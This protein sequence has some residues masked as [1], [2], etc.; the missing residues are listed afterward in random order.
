[1]TTIR[2]TLKRL[3]PRAARDAIVAAR[4][5]LSA[6]PL[7]Q[8]VLHDY[9]IIEDPAP[10]G[11]LTLVMP[12]LASKTIFGG[13]STGV[14]ILFACAQALKM[15]VRV[16]ID[17]FGDPTDFSYVKGVAQ[18]VAFAHGDIEFVARSA[19]TQP[20][21]VRA[22]DIFI[23]FNWWVALNLR[24]MLAQQMILRSA[25]KPRPLLYIVQDYEPGFYPWSSTHMVARAAFDS[26]GRTFGI[27]N[28]HELHDY[29][30]AQGHAYERE[31]VIPL[32]MSKS[33]KNARSGAEAP[34][35]KTILVYGRPGVA[36]NCFP[37]VVAGLKAFVHR[38]PEYGDWRLESAGGDHDAIDLGS[39]KLLSPLGKLS[40]ENYAHKLASAGVGL[41]LMASPHPSYPP[42]EMAHFGV[43]TVTNGYACKDL[44]KAHENILSIRDV[45]PETIAAGL[46]RQCGAVLSDRQG[47]WR[48]KSML[49]DYLSDDGYP[50]MNDLVAA[51]RQEAP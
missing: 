13:V 47:G 24:G 42:L 6:P 7:E 21:S 33:L 23:A 29:F 41:S 28:S 17:D 40:L 37:A 26:E 31:F 11:R 10:E 18:R 32:R 9:E 2:E 22:N 12:S 20:I 35:D 16:V 38:Y 48:S 44:S 19:Q 39:G 4:A 50:F 15:P 51:L 30:H 49:P 8:I 36:R 1:M 43:R 14:D 45:L 25:Q 5:K 3:A 27:F 46:A 34:K